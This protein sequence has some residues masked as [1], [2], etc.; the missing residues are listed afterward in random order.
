M[1][2]VKMSKKLKEEILDNAKGLFDKQLSRM[3]E[4][5]Q[6]YGSIHAS[7]QDHI[8]HKC[9]KIEWNKNI[10]DEVLALAR[11]HDLI[12]TG[13]QHIVCYQ[14]TADLKVKILE[15]K[16]DEPDK[17]TYNFSH[18]YTIRLQKDT[19]IQSLSTNGW[20]KD[21]MNAVWE[22]ERSKTYED[23]HLQHM[24]DK[25][26][27]M[28]AKKNEREKF[29]DLVKSTLEV[30]N[31]LRQ[32]LKAWPEGQSLVPDEYLNELNRKTGRNKSKV[33]EQ[34]D[35]ET[36]KALSGTLLINKMQQD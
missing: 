32:F 26:K 28:M 25:I 31:S 13:S 35:E 8:V 12:G 2:V 7:I 5:V 29:I 17:L 16:E 9:N 24:V 36:R 11:K 10:H 27:T 15:P 22:F 34:L 21:N 3:T 18:N 1:A 4:E 33:E 6:N 14:K 30:A 20:Q 19:Y 23:V